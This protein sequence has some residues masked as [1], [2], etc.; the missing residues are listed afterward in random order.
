MLALKATQ[1]S[2]GCEVFVPCLATQNADIPMLCFEDFKKG[3]QRLDNTAHNFIVLN[4]TSESRIKRFHWAWNW[5]VVFFAVLSEW[6]HV[7]HWNLYKLPLII[8]KAEPKVGH[9]S[10]QINTTETIFCLLGW[11]WKIILRCFSCYSSKIA[12]IRLQN[13]FF[14]LI[15][16][17]G[18][19]LL[20]QPTNF[21]LQSMYL[22]ELW[23][24]QSIL[25]DPYLL[26]CAVV[27]CFEEMQCL[28]LCNLH[29]FKEMN[30]V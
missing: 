13:G 21:P 1:F 9:M 17:M 11:V 22:T 12:S 3:K 29:C 26:C 8:I 27:H 30:C 10:D 4:W 5:P 7:V 2:L 15:N 25:F 18:S 6:V 14:A 20:G 16:H 24:T 23:N 19:V 28:L